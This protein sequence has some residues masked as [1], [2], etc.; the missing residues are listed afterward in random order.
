MKYF[1]MFSGI[2]GFE[3]G[4]ELGISRASNNKDSMVQANGE[5]DVLE[6][7]SSP[8][9]LR[10]GRSEATCCRQGRGN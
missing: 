5:M 3:R 9:S 10:V 6:D 8:D 1:S 4:I 2:G 7:M